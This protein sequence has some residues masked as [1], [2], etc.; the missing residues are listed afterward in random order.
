[1]PNELDVGVRNLFMKEFFPL[2][3]FLFEIEDK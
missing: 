2:K 1:M 3:T